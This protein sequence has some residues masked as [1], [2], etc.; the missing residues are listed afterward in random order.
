MTLSKTFCTVNI[1]SFF[2]PFKTKSLDVVVSSHSHYSAFSN[3]KVVCA[4]AAKGNNEQASPG[5]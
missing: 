3:G 5:A 1:V 2:L 4:N